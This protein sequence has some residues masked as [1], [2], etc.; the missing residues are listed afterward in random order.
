MSGALARD[1]RA[2]VAEITRRLA[3]A[4]PEVRIGIGDD[5]AVLVPTR[6]GDALSVDANV[7]GVH[8][9]RSLLS[10]REIG[11]RATVAALS[12]LAAMGATPRALLSALVVPEALDDEALFELVDG[13][14]EAADA[15]GAHVVGGNL[16]TGGELSITTTVVGHAPPSPLTR[17]GARAGDALFVTGT[18]GGAALGLALL[19]AGRREPAMIVARYMRPSARVHE[20]ARLVGVATAAIDVSDGLLLDLERLCE[21]SGVG[22]TLRAAAIPREPGLDTHAPPVGRDALT[23]ALTGGDDYEL[24]FTAP[25][26]VALSI[27]A[28]RIGEVVA[29]PGVRLLDASGEPLPLPPVHGWG[30]SH[31]P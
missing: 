20:G 9:R 22:A 26:T 6:H 28:T 17:A 27:A 1:E 23:L 19:E 14:A 5:A 15:Y 2:R 29:A 10:D 8:F 24:L 4:S 30:H 25:P 18:L 31:S 7:E 16:T 3:R 12:D 11:F 13:I 21:A